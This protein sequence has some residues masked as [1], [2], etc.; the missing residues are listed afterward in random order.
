MRLKHKATI[1]FLTLNPV[2]TGL[3]SSPKLITQIIESFSYEGKLVKMYKKSW[4][5]PSLTS[6]FME[7]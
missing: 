4:M 7:P 5:L 1:S 3:V 6:L 2:N